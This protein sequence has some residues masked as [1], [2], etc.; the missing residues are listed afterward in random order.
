MYGTRKSSRPK[1]R[2]QPNVGWSLLSLFFY[3]F[4]LVVIPNLPKSLTLNGYYPIAMVIYG[5]IGVFTG[6]GVFRLVRNASD[7]IKWVII[8]VLYVLVVYQLLSH[9]DRFMVPN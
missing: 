5:T 9:V 6:I 8:I 3:F 1:I 4:I 7:K 2:L